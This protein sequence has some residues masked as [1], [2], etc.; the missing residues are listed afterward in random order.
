MAPKGRPRQRRDGKEV[1]ERL[2]EA[3][4]DLIETHFAA[5]RPPASDALA[6]VSGIRVAEKVGVARSM[7][8]HYWGSFDSFL[9]EVS[10][11]VWRRALDFEHLGQLV[12]EAAS[13][14]TDGG[15]PDVADLLEA[16]TEAEIERVLHSA[17]WRASILLA[18]YGVEPPSADRG[19]YWEGLEQ[20]YRTTFEA[21]GLEPRAG[22]TYRDI[23]A[24]ISAA[25]EGQ[26]LLFLEDPSQAM[27]RFEWR[28]RITGANPRPRDWTAYQLTVDALVAGLTQ[29]SGASGNEPSGMHATEDPTSEH[30]NDGGSAPPESGSSA[31]RRRR[32][33]PAGSAAELA[34]PRPADAELRRCQV[35]AVAAARGH[36]VRGLVDPVAPSPDE[37]ALT[38]SDD[39]EVELQANVAA[40]CGILPYVRWG[41]SPR[42]DLVVTVVPDLSES[43]SRSADDPGADLLAVAE[44]SGGSFLTGRPGR[45]PDGQWVVAPDREVEAVHFVVVDRS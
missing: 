45:L 37:F 19:I 29:R 43:A 38:R 8:T 1:R 20:L 11:L 7:I 23:A 5:T 16:L 15:L 26:A 34:Q 25:T 18:L 36:V 22:I 44:L 41:V 3:G 42:G 27:Q 14:V 12:K 24:A 35:V 6:M 10:D 17:P 21:L 13:Q 2:L 31:E 4:A 28:S 9:S 40:R 30:A 33:R 39:N 32:D